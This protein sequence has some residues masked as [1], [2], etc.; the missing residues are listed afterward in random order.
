M[1]RS[2]LSGLVL[3]HGDRNIAPT[4]QSIEQ[5]CSQIVVVNDLSDPS[6]QLENGSQIAFEGEV[7]VVDRFF[8]TFPGQR[9]A[10]LEKASRE[11][12]LVI[13]SDETASES[14][15]SDIAALDHD[16]DTTVFAI[17]R[18]EIIR[19]REL[20]KV[21]I[22][23]PHPRLFRSSHRYALAPAV[24]ERLENWPLPSIGL[25]QGHILHDHH[26]DITD[27]IR[28]EF[29]YGLEY[30]HYTDQETQDLS[31]YE[32]L[33]QSCGDIVLRN[34]LLEG[35][36]GAIAVAANISSRIGEKLSRQSYGNH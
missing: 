27:L 25:L 11:W 9:N 18:R 10:G 23:G 24:H 16:V 28:T 2:E 29:R 7:T 26:E 32:I 36:G 5:V 1:F 12:V 3:T 14:L 35:S 20:E 15:C 6:Q 22:G 13:D 4:L 30:G 19:G 17:P 31:W 33:R 8:D 21:S 34:G